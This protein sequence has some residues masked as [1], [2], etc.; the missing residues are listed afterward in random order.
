MRNTATLKL[1]AVISLLFLV[2]CSTKA[3]Q[4]STT[5]HTDKPTA[6]TIFTKKLEVK[7]HEYKKEPMNLYATN[8]ETSFFAN[9]KPRD[10]KTTIIALTEWNNLKDGTEYVVASEW[11]DPYGKERS[12]S[13]ERFIYDGKYNGKYKT[14]SVFLPNE[15]E[16][17]ETGTWKVNIYLNG[18]LIESP[19]FH[20]E[21][22]KHYKNQSY[23]R[24]EV[25]DPQNVKTCCNLLIEPKEKTILSSK[26]I[27]S[28]NA[29]DNESQ[30]YTHGKES[31]TF[32]IGPDNRI[33]VYNLWK[34]HDPDRKYTVHF[35][36]FGPKNKLRHQSS[37]SS[38]PRSDTWS[39]WDSI[40]ISPEDKLK[41]G[42]WDVEVIVEYREKTEEETATPYIHKERATFTL[43]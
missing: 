33:Y 43:E 39:T 21:S 31:T 37:Y 8:V 41:K 6:K 13:A 25:Y 27:R 11:L 4:T 1:T 19:T 17:R 7:E 15:V 38:T 16:N 36:W 42:Q 20:L 26:I 23:M 10:T 2:G 32:K 29:P 40:R 35:Q 9:T 34:I 3:I 30:N 12:S 28:G 22:I 14:Q 5:K 24:M 18:E